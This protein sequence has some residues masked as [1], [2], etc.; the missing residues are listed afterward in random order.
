[1]PV[2]NELLYL[3]LLMSIDDYDDYWCQCF[4]ML[5]ICPTYVLLPIREGNSNFV[6]LFFLAHCE[7]RTED[8][9]SLNK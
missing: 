5:K 2:L 4:V 7:K 1:M 8:N 9:S 3:S 6:D